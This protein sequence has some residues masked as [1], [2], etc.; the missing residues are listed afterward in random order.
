MFAV[1]L[2]TE[3]HK[4]ATGIPN[5]KVKQELAFNDYKR[6][7]DNTSRGNIKYT[8]LISGKT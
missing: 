7:L 3:L 4:K 5:I 2:E 6:T 8:S 1:K